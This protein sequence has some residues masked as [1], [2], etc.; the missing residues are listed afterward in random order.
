MFVSSER[1]LKAITLY[2][3]NHEHII[4]RIENKDLFV[5]LRR[6]ANGVYL[7][8][9]ERKGTVR[10]TVLIP[11]SGILR[12]KNVL[13]EALQISMKNVKIRYA[14]YLVRSARSMMSSPTVLSDLIM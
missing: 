3:Y 10:N 7:K 6:N 1:K 2:L 13:E 12:L 8:L 9:S 14:S 5:D 11:A 4:C